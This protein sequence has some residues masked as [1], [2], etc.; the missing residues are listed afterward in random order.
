V[1]VRTGLPNALEYFDIGALLDQAS[2]EAEHGVWRPAHRLGDLGPTGA[3]VAG[4]ARPKVDVWIDAH[5]EPDFSSPVD[6]RGDHRALRQRHTCSES[7]LTQANSLI[8][9]R[10]CD[11]RRHR[12]KRSYAVIAAFHPCFRVANA[13]VTFYRDLGWLPPA[14]DIRT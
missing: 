1:I 8:I 9:L 5:A 11:A 4:R 13:Q 12:S 7:K 3:L 2:E 6:G 14:A 10:R